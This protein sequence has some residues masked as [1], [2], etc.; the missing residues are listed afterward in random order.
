MAKTTKATTMATNHGPRV[1][2]HPD[3]TPDASR[4][5]AA[6]LMGL[7]R[8]IAVIPCT[9]NGQTVNTLATVEMTERGPAFAPIALLATNA[10]TAML[11]GPAGTYVGT[12]D[13]RPIEAPKEA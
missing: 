13:G 1:A 3:C 8:P 6:L 9:I 10:L 7:T 12:A 11:T 2:F 4:T 5:L